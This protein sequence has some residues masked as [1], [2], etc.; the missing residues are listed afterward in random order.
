MIVFFAVFYFDTSTSQE[1]EEHE[2]D[3][4]RNSENK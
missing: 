4:K 2:K 1:E 3:G